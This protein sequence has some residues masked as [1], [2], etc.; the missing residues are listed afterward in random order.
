MKRHIFFKLLFISNNQQIWRAEARSQSPFRETILP[1]PGHH[2]AWDRHTFQICCH[3]RTLLA[4]PNP[5][6]AFRRIRPRPQHRSLDRQHPAHR[7]QHPHRLWTR[8]QKCHHLWRLQHGPKLAAQPSRLPTGVSHQPSE[9]ARPQPHPGL[10][11]GTRN[12]RQTRTPHAH[13]PQPP[14]LKPRHHLLETAK[15]LPQPAIHQMHQRLI[16][17]PPTAPARH[18]HPQGADHGG[19][20]QK[21]RS[22]GAHDYF[23]IR[24][25]LQMQEE[26]R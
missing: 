24:K 7:R 25:P 10:P 26:N 19:E 6:A 4:R 3:A 15:N 5:H 18:R 17:P 21:G 11:S 23:P 16:Q 20:A 9:P 8:R 2:T 22:N 14:R 12:R 13:R 1:D